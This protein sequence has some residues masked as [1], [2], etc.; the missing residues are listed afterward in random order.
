[1]SERKNSK[2]E[3]VVEIDWEG[4]FWELRSLAIAVSQGPTPMDIKVDIDSIVK[5]HTK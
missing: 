3:R 5:A 4:A 2:D 1:M